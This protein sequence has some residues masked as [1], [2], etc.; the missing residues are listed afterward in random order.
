MADLRRRRAR[1]RGGRRRALFAA[2]VGTFAAVVGGGGGAAARLVDDGRPATDLGERRRPIPIVLAALKSCPRSKEQHAR[3]A[4]RRGRRGRGRRESKELQAHAREGRVPRQDV[5]VLAARVERERGRRQR[6]VREACGRGGEISA[7]YERRSRPRLQRWNAGVVV[8]AAPPPRRASARLHGISTRRG[9]GV[10]SA[11]LHGR[12]TSKP[13]RRRDPTSSARADGQDLRSA[14]G[15]R[16][17]APRPACGSPNCTVPSRFTPV[18][19][20]NIPSKFWR[21]F[22][23]GLTERSRLP[24]RTDAAA[25][26]RFSTALV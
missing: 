2:V 21:K 8:G 19:I 26:P 22:E 12:S 15:P 1:R 11:R 18:V 4:A 14:A 25:T 24:A 3:T 9:R 17:G 6:A 23:A 16:R 10:A 5:L 7:K 20:L 13:R